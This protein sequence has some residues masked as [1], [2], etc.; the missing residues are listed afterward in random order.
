MNSKKEKRVSEIVERIINWLSD[1]PRPGVITKAD[2]IR[3]GFFDIGG[4]VYE[5]GELALNPPDWF[6]DGI[7]RTEIT[8]GDNLIFGLRSIFDRNIKVLWRKPISFYERKWTFINFGTCAIPQTQLKDIVIRIEPASNGDPRMKDVVVYISEKE[9]ER[10][11]NKLP[12]FV[13]FP[14]E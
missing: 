10:H 13:P 5:L 11:K 4:L 9:L 2:W 1:M 3:E 8:I 6:F 7:Y 14:V 12:P